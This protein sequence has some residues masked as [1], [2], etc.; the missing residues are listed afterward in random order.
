MFFGDISDY[1]CMPSI[2]VMTAFCCSSLSLSNFCTSEF[3]SVSSLLSLK[4]SDRLIPSALHMF[5]RVAID[6]LVP[7][8]Y[9]F[10]SVDGVRSASLLSLYIVQ[11]FCIRNSSILF[12]TSIVTSFP[13]L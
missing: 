12:N 9:M 4:K 11:P 2:I 5:V 3:L 1:F 10:A 13:L 8:A 6:G 7:L